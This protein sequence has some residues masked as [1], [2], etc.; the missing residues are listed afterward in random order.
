MELDLQVVIEGEVVVVRSQVLLHASKVFREMLQTPMVEGVPNQMWLT[1]K[2]KAEFKVF[3][4]VLSWETP[5]TQENAIFL[6]VWA[7]EYDVQSLKKW[8][9]L[10]I[11]RMPIT[12][13][14]LNHA[15]FHKLADREAQCV[16]AISGDIRAYLD[17]IT[18]MGS[19]MLPAAMER[20]WPSI[21]EAARVQVPFPE[22][23]TA[24]H[25]FW[26]FVVRA[27]NS[28]PSEKAAPWP[29]QLHAKRAD[30][31][32]QVIMEETDQGMPKEITESPLEQAK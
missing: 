3:W 13:D 17:E 32:Q 18:E 29:Q 9:E 22:G 8:C 24:G 19:K 20:L 5:V 12:C 10:C 21:C 31:I 1:N 4:S 2:S 28:I 15:V 27:C 16:S 23:F 14:A 11:M 25:T 7:S 30:P 6:S 26:P